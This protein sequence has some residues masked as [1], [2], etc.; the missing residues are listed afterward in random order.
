[1][2]R[3]P[4]VPA[5]L[6]GKLWRCIIEFEMLKE[7]DRVLIGLSGGKD[8]M[9]LTAALAE[10][11]Q[12]A[13][14]KF[15]LACYTVDTMFSTDFPKTDLESFCAQYGLKHYSSKVDVTEAW[16]HRTNTPCFTCAYFRRAATNRTALELGFNKVAWAHHH[17]DAVETFFLNLVAS[18]Q[19]KTFLPV[20][21]LSRTGLTL[22]RP[23][24]YYREA[25]IISMV[26]ELNLHPLKNPCSYDGHTKRQEAK[27]LLRSL[28]CFNAEAYDHLAAAMRFAN[29]ELWPAKCGKRSWQINSTHFG[30]KSAKTGRN[31]AAR[32]EYNFLYDILTG[33]FL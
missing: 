19:L 30:S 13:P 14:F 15:D 24:L 23:L 10:V 6:L 9:F 8:S 16:Q 18:G 29:A 5:V 1:M 22:I 7:G 21:P 28:Q 2:S 11:Q 25:E 17:D 32:S 26:D 31:N 3:K 12:Y 20:T 33:G 27:E 4:F